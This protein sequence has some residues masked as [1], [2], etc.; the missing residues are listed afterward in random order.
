MIE[1]AAF[2]QF[3][4]PGREHVPAGDHML[5]NTE[6]QHKRKYLVA[7]GTTVDV[8]GTALS[9]GD[10]CFWGEWEPPSRVVH[11]WDRM[12][13]LPTVVHEPFWVSPGPPGFRQNTDPWVFGREF[14]Y[15]NCKQIVRVSNATSLQR[16]LA[17]SVILFGSTLGGQFVLDTVFVVAEL[18]CRWIPVAGPKIGNPVFQECTVRSCATG[19][20][21]GATFT[22]ASEMS[23]V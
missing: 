23:G 13:G 2:V 16:L 18:A 11:R 15:S 14:L 17:G 8:S 4:H 20:H 6:S 9:S 1:A 19:R 5:W 10:F 21:A 3:P 22:G 7:S 12:A